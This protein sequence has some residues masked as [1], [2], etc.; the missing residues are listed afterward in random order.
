MDIIS[1]LKGFP[2]VLEKIFLHLDVA[3]ISESEKVSPKWKRLITSLNIW[4]CVWNKNMKRS[5]SWK[6]LSVRMEHIQPQLSEQ[7]KEFLHSGLQGLEL[8]LLM[9][10]Q[11]QLKIEFSY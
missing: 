1:Q 9:L 10:I 7:M 11:E 3:T 4:M 8:L 6:T 2:D 5:S